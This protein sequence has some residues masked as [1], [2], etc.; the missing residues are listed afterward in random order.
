MKRT[1]EYLV[2]GFE[3]DSMK[4]SFLNLILILSQ[5]QSSLSDFPQSIRFLF[6]FP[7]FIENK[8]TYIF[9]N[10]RKFYGS[11]EKGL[12]GKKIE[13]NYAT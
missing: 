10:K 4:L 6:S 3:Y 7:V 11:E 1:H 9:L 13:E 8:K 5:N 12:S 2:S